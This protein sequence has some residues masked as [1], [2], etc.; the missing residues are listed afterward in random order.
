MLI[1]G[2]HKTPTPQDNYAPPEITEWLKT[3]TRI[4]NLHLDDHGR[5]AECQNPWPCQ[6]ARQADLALAGL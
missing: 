4:I 1:M 6:P 2:Q 5:C 3:A